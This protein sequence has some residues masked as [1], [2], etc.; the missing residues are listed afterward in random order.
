[1]PEPN[2]V[3]FLPQAATDWTFARHQVGA[4]VHKDGRQA[5]IVVRRTVQQQDARLSGD[6][7]ADLVRELETTA[8]FEM[9]FRKENLRMSEQLPLVLRRQATEGSN[10]PLDDALP[11]GGKG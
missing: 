9:L 6:G 4:R 5:W 3:A 10:V 1:V 11:L 2:L 8:A 7:D